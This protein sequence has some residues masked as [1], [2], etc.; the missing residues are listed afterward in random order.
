MQILRFIQWKIGL[1]PDE[2]GIKGSPTYVSRAFRPENKR[3]ECS[4][5][6]DINCIAD[7]IKE[8]GGLNG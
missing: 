1:T 6:E 3:G 8:F 4:F 5:C 2:V 7:K